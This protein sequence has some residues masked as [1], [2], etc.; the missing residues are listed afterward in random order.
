MVHS[1]KISLLLHEKAALS[2]AISVASFFFVNS[3]LWGT[4]V[5]L[6]HKVNFSASEFSFWPVNWSAKLMRA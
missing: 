5:L 3:L 1:G 2:R 6:E 4:I